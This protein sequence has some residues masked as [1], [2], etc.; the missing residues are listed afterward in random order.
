[1]ER[2]SRT[3]LRKADPTKDPKED[4]DDDSRWT[5]PQTRLRKAD[6]TKDPDDDSRWTGQAVPVH[7]KQPREKTQ[8]KTQM[9]TVG[10]TGKQYPFKKSRPDKGPEEDQ[11]DDSRWTGPRTRL[12]KVDPTKEKQTRQKKSR[13]DKRPRRRPG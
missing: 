7:E 3:R 2:A 6:P 10:G 8:E 4:P 11:D 1:M 12:R 9:T 5:G 13:P